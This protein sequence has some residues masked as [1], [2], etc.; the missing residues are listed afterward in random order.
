MTTKK[1]EESRQRAARQR[2]REEK[3]LPASR[4]APTEARGGGKNEVE[5]VGCRTGTAREAASRAG[6]GGEGEY[7][8]GAE[9]AVVFRSSKEEATGFIVYTTGGVGEREG[10]WRRTVE[11]SWKEGGRNGVDVLIYYDVLYVVTGSG[12]RRT[13]EERCK[14]RAKK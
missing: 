7:G 4:G 12:E 9:A 3:T 5:K 11:M 10:G 1:G 14:E 6:G 8:E 13:N 2:E